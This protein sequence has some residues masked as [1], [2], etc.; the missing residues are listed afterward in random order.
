MYEIIRECIDCTKYVTFGDKLWLPGVRPITYHVVNSMVSIRD[1]GI[2]RLILYHDV[3]VWKRV[4]YYFCFCVGNHWLQIDSPHR[5]Q[6]I[7]GF[8]LVFRLNSLSRVSVT[9]QLLEWRYKTW[10]CNRQLI[11]T[12]ISADLTETDSDNGATG[13]LTEWYPRRS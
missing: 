9:G 6:I 7:R 12:C 11:F 8:D 1:R 10:Y 4:P 3:M 5:G 13:Q 2:S